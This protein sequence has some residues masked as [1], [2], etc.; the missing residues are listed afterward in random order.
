MIVCGSNPTVRR[1]TKEDQL[2]KEGVYKVGQL[3]WDCKKCGEVWR[4]HEGHRDDAEVKEFLR[5]EASG[6]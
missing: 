5:K 3:L 2:V 4:I 1:A 6:G